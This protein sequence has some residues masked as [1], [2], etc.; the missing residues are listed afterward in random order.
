MEKQLLA[1]AG[2][3]QASGSYEEEEEEK[4]LDETFIV[5]QSPFDYIIE[6]TRVQKKPAPRPATITA[7]SGGA[8]AA[9]AT[10][11]EA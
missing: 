10:S 4:E 2:A 1:E 3:A 9:P 11:V 6:E 5:N 8:T 7:S